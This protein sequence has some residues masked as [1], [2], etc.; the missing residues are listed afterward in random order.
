MRITMGMIAKQYNKKLNKSLSDLNYLSNRSVSLRKF[1]NASEDPVSAVKAFK[2][3]RELA[4]NANYQTNITDAKSLMQ[5]AEG[6]MMQ[7]NSIAQQANSS[8]IIQAITD[9]MS[10]EDRSIVAT[11]LKKLQEAVV[12]IMNTQFSDKYIFGGSSTKS[13]PFSLDA[14][15]NLLYRN[16][17]V[18][19]GEHAG[20]EGTAAT[21]NISGA[22]IDFG[23][24]NGSAFNDYMIKVTD[25]TGAYALDTDAKT[26]TIELDFAT[27]T[28]QDLQDSLRTAFTAAGLPG[29]DSNLITVQDL[30]SPI[31][32][33]GTGIVSG[34]EDPIA[35]GT[36]VDLN[37]LAKEQ[38]FV[39]LGLGLKFDSAGKLVE[40]SAFD[41]SLP[42]ISFL[43]FGETSDGTPK[44]I[45]ALLGDIA[46]KL[47]D[48][49]YTFDGIKADLDM[50]GERYQN[51][52]KGITEFGTK[53]N[54]LSYT[55]TRLEE[56]ELNINERVSEIEYVDIE[57][58]IMDYKM[59]QYAYQ[60][61]LKMGVQVI[62]P[63]F[64]DFMR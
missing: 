1:V 38:V 51:L 28:K 60:A 56:A 48:P 6:A 52:L 8:D 4:S 9:T 43:G 58:A 24:A 42:G 50:F 57:T 36:A 7:I 63:S 17:N 39:D 64:L 33:I 26:L 46:K 41:I 34:G 59:Q 14:D 16:V 62:Q 32:S 45:H 3:R 11:K 12:T 61:A 22:Q 37:A 18:S 25:G 55:Q 47:E 53:S 19:T 30:A 31:T 13:A 44:N 10:T 29:T 27:A 54:F 2:A 49:S 23:K 15:G 40:Q 5:T 35:A 21:L 20:F